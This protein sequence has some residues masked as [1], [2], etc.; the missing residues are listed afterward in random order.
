MEKKDKISF[1]D[2]GAEG[3]CVYLPASVKAGTGDIVS[4][5][6]RNGEVKR[7]LL[8]EELIR[9]RGGARYFRFVDEIYL[10]EEE[11]ADISPQERVG[12]AQRATEL[13]K[14]IFRIGS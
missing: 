5:R 1:R 8:G 10:E 2:L 4:V 14:A 9:S 13:I 6:K 12:F 11:G 3:W 7:V